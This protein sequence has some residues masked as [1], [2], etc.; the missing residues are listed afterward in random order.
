MYHV[1]ENTITSST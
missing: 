1:E